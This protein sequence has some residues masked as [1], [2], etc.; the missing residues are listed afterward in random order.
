MINKG[1][2]IALTQCMN[3]KKDESCL[4]VTDP[5]KRDIANI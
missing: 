4:I 5:G 2:R 1:A 3:L